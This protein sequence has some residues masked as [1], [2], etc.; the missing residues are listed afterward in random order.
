[1]PPI[2]M[3]TTAIQSTAALSKWPTE[4][5]EVEKPPVAMVVMAWAIASNPLM[6]ASQ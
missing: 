4:E 3:N 1:M 5:S 2:S 6:P